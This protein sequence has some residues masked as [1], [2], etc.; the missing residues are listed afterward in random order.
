M[1]QLCALKD[2]RGYQRVVFKR[3][4][5]YRCALYLYVIFF[6]LLDSIKSDALLA[7][8]LRSYGMDT[9]F[10]QMVRVQVVMHVSETILGSLVGYVL[11]KFLPPIHLL[12]SSFLFS[13]IG[14]TVFDGEK[15]SISLLVSVLVFRALAAREES[16]RQCFAPSE[17]C[18]DRSVSTAKFIGFMDMEPRQSLTLQLCRTVFVSTI[19]IIVFAAYPEIVFGAQTPMMILAATTIIIL[20]VCTVVLQL[21]EEGSEEGTPRAF[22]AKEHNSVQILET[23]FH[24]FEAGRS[25][26]YPIYITYAYVYLQLNITYQSVYIHFTLQAVRLVVA[27]MFQVFNDLTFDLR[28]FM[29]VRMMRL[30]RYGQVFMAVVAL[31]GPL[32]SQFILLYFLTAMTGDAPIDVGTCTAQLIS[33]SL[34]LVGT[35]GAFDYVVRQLI[36][37]ER[38]WRCRHVTRRPS[39]TCCDLFFVCSNAPRGAFYV[40]FFLL[41]CT[42]PTWSLPLINIAM[43]SSIVIALLVF[44]TRYPIER[45][46]CRFI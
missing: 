24:A 42:L 36:E 13:L 38:R 2:L 39:Y 25:I 43:F 22:Q 19:K 10:S 18:L 32:V 1:E 37:Q 28:G 21:K 44:V 12:V 11:S 14:W 4:L 29:D 27:L 5:W 30:I 41:V 34:C 17:D 31:A 6:D 3:Y 46:R 26:D 7:Y 9:N 45:T 8:L 20:V 33:A 40:L 15:T 35:G 16:V 23:L